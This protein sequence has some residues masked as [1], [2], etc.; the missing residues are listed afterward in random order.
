MALT[1]SMRN[2]LNMLKTTLSNTELDFGCMERKYDE[3]VT[4]RFSS[5]RACRFDQRIASQCNS[6]VARGGCGVPGGGGAPNLKMG[7]S[8]AHG[9]LL[10][11]K[12]YPVGT[13][14]L[15]RQNL[16]KSEETRISYFRFYK[17]N[18]FHWNLMP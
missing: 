18:F 6:T 2:F 9:G 11:L 14:Q 15:F 10:N 7:A 12:N 1:N 17:M 16:Q 3:K 5:T 13:C 4:L 8:I